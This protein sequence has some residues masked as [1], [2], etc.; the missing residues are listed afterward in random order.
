MNNIS[1]IPRFDLDYTIISAKNCTGCYGP[2]NYD[3]EKSQQMGYMK[4]VEG[5]ENTKTRLKTIFSDPIS[6][7]GVFVKDLMSPNET[8][9]SQFTYA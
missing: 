8:Q 4:V 7:N 3:D 6:L 2:Q 5:T 9:A 1:M